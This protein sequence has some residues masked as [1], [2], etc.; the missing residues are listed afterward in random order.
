LYGIDYKAKYY[1]SI[2]QIA[3][4][5]IWIFMYYWKLEIKKFEIFFIYP[6]VLKI[7]FYSSFQQVLVIFAVQ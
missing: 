5:G 1:Y 3:G 6:T 7:S 2:K 4:E